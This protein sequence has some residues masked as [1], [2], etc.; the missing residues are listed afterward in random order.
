MR[1]RVLGNT[2]VSLSAIGFGASLLGDVFGPVSRSGDAALIGAAIDRGINFFDVS[3]YYGSGLAEERLGIA[4]A[5]HRKN[6][7]LATKCGRHG[8]DDFDFSA[9]GIRSQVEASLRRLRADSVD[10]LQA[11]DVEFGDVEQIIH[12]TLPALAELKREGKARFIG[13]TGY[14][15]GLLAQIVQSHPVDSVLNYC[16]WN[17]FAN[18]M[19]ALLTPATQAK[20][21]GLIN[22]SPLHMGL[23]GGGPIPEW[24]PAP[25]TIRAVARSVVAECRGRSIDPATLA[26]WKCLQHPV[27]ASTLV[28]MANA[29]EVA[30]SCAALE[31]QPEE[32]LLTA[33]T[34]SIHPVH[35]AAWPQG[36][37]QNQDR[38]HGHDSLSLESR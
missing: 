25:E 3:P 35:N 5:P 9:E 8:T 32:D 18:D 24:H 4:L 17:L 26:V 6:V 23:L 10:L 27:T 13:I 20:G 16:H 14:W 29:S 31:F 2:G 7:V 21:V 12:E 1:Y 38:A 33:I 19:D 30:S 15:P 28:G 11:H 37:Q 34:E 36:R 22:A